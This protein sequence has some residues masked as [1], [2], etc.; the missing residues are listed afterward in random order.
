MW[1][2]M[3]NPRTCDV[4]GNM[5]VLVR[6]N[7]LDLEHSVAQLDYPTIQIECSAASHVLTRIRLKKPLPSPKSS[8]C[9]CPAAFSLR[10]TTPKQCHP[11]KARIHS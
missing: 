1:G 4:L 9:E 3:L 6:A 5:M 2:D 10:L 8:G 11:G 7:R